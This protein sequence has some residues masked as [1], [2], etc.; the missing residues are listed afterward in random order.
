MVQDENKELRCI[1][2]ELEFPFVSYATTILHLHTEAPLRLR[3]LTHVI[4]KTATKPFS[5]VK[6]CP[7]QHSK[8]VQLVSEALWTFSFQPSPIKGKIPTDELPLYL[9]IL[10]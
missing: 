6:R 9:S 10:Y 8:S 2:V 7:P 5:S 4:L 1:Y 3:N